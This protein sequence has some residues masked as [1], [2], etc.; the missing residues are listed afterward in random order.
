MTY[1]RQMPNRSFASGAKQVTD[2]KV[3]KAGGQQIERRSACV[4]SKIH[5]KLQSA[6]RVPVPARWRGCVTPCYKASLM[7]E[8]ILSIVVVIAVFSGDGS[9]SC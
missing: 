5:D 8:L 6:P 7:A 4:W 2:L 1:M 3:V 9:R